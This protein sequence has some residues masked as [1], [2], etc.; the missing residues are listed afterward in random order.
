MTQNS[1]ICVVG[2]QDWEDVNFYGVFNQCG[3]VRLFI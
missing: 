3:G 2:E 1:G